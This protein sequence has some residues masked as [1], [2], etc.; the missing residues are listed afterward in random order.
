MGT[1]RLLGKNSA[2]DIGKKV[3]IL[4]GM[5]NAYLLTGHCFKRTSITWCADAG[6]SIPQ[7]KAHTGHK[8]DTVVQGNVDQSM[9]QK[10]LAAHAI[11]GNVVGGIRKRDWSE[12]C[13]S[14]KK[15]FCTHPLGKAATPDGGMNTYYI[16]S[17]GTV[18]IG[19]VKHM[20][21]DNEESDE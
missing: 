20:H 14:P 1:K 7:I 5:K 21:K 2:A 4:L 10:M 8:S 15:S 3:G 12:V 17:G 16:V 6:M 19:M 9:P 11:A 18:N 13:D